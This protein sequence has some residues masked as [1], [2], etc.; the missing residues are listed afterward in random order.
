MHKFKELTSGFIGVDA[1]PVTVYDW[2][3]VLDAIMAKADCS[4]CGRVGHAANACEY[5][6]HVSELGSV[7]KHKRKLIPQKFL[8]TKEDA[9]S[10]SS[11]TATHAPLGYQLVPLPS[12]P[13][14]S[15]QGFNDN[16]PPNFAG[17]PHGMPYGPPPPGFGPYPPNPPHGA[18]S[19]TQQRRP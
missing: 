19:T 13:N 18:G 8:A 2:T 5:I 4:H 11:T 16:F 3:G 15:P 9:M 7:G 10:T 6:A 14:F 17:F 12:G 1:R